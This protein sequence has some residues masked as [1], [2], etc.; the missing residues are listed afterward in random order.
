MKIDW[1][2][3]S[4]AQNAAGDYILGV[5][6]LAWPKHN[7]LLIAMRGPDGQIYGTSRIGYADGTRSIQG[8]RG[9]AEPDDASIDRLRKIVTTTMAHLMLATGCHP[10]SP[11][12]VLDE[13]IVCGDRRKADGLLRARPWVIADVPPPP[14]LD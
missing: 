1:D 6:Y 5:W 2:A 13:V 10:M 9:P 14:P 11:D 4:P 8:M 7:W 3:A 12:V